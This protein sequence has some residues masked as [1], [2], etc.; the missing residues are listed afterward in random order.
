MIVDGPVLVTVEPA[1]TAKLAVVPRFT[2][3]SA[4]AAGRIPAT[5]MTRA[6]VNGMVTRR[7]QR[8]RAARRS[9]GEGGGK[10]NDAFRHELA[11]QSSFPV[12]GS[13][14]SGAGGRGNHPIGRTTQSPDRCVLV[15]REARTR[16]GVRVQ[17]WAE[18][19]RHGFRN[20]G[21]A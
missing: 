7:A 20:G 17:V 12:A 10:M 6:T 1:R 16:A 5:S 14:F 18:R 15:P 13:H 19:C 11:L 3:A 2:G 4:A 21:N 9:L 8:R